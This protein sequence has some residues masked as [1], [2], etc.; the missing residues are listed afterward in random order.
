MTAH[1]WDMDVWTDEVR[2]PPYAD[3]EKVDRVLS[4]LTETGKHKFELAM[5][6]AELRGG[7]E[8]VHGELHAWY[9]TALHVERPGFIER[10]RAAQESL[11]SGSPWS[12]DDLKVLD[13]LASQVDQ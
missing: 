9:R 2:V 1:A 5:R 8:A 13:D 4:R 3:R 10:I 6:H 7:P 11:H 12:D